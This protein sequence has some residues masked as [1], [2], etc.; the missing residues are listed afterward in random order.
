[1]TGPLR[2]HAV[3]GSVAVVAGRRVIAT[4]PLVAAR[5][6]PA[7]KPATVSL[8]FITRPFTLVIAVVLIATLTVLVVFR[9]GRMRGKRAEPA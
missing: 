5:A 2:R 8:D 7:P 9:R 4:V 3:I 6:V 1:V